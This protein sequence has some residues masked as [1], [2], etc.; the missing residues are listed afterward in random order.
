MNLFFIAFIITG[1][2]CF[3]I[4]GVHSYLTLVKAHLQMLPDDDFNTNYFKIRDALYDRMYHMAKKQWLQTPLLDE[5][6]QKMDFC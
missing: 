6:V 1:M 4:D 2:L 5:C 3:Y